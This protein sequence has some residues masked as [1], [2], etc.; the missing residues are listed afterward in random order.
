MGRSMLSL[1]RNWTELPGPEKTNKGCLLSWVC[2]S[3]LYEKLKCG[4]SSSSNASS[5]KP[6]K[7]WKLP[8]Y[9][10]Q[11]VDEMN[12]EMHQWQEQQT[13]QRQQ[14]QLLQQQHHKKG[15][16]RVATPAAHHGMGIMCGEAC[17]AKVRHSE[18]CV[19][20]KALQEAFSEPHGQRD[21]AA[22]PP[23]A[24]GSPVLGRSR[25]AVPPSAVNGHAA[26]GQPPPQKNVNSAV[27][28]C[29]SAIECHR[30]CHEK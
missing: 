27:D 30:Q 4:N 18:A 7:Q 26:P 13:H 11:I 28:R 9:I 10:H 6:P 16:V 2:A 15:C 3:S 25:P 14:L 23:L 29:V 1:I 24:D 8:A 17:F 20:G 19:T 21:V 22:C 5:S 12:A